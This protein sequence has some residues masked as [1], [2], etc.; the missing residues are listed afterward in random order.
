M[1]QVY[2]GKVLVNA[3]YKEGRYCKKNINGGLHQ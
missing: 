2:L 1:V 3:Q